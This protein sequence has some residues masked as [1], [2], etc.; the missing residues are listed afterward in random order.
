MKKTSAAKFRNIVGRRV[1]QARLRAKPPVSQDD[2][3]GRLAARGIILDRTAVSRIESQSRYVMDYE[4]AALARALRV[5][6]AWLFGEGNSAG[7]P[8]T[9][10]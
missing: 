3:A 9:R 6:V 8:A 4:A 10:F 5:P 2:L 7:R 1:R